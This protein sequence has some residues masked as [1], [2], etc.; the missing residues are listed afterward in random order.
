LFLNTFYSL[1]THS[2]GICEIFKSLIHSG[3]Q[4]TELQ[5]RKVH[6]TLSAIRHKIRIHTYNIHAT[7]D[8]SPNGAKASRSVWVSISGLRSPTN[9]W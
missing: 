4:I 1:I 9:M 6:G 3:Y 2:E 5:R 7:Y 8:I